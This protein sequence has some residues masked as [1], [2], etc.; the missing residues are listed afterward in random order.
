MTGPES[1]GD[2][3]AVV[4][5]VDGS[6]AALRAVRWAAGEAVRRR[7]TLLLVHATSAT[8]LHAGPASAGLVVEDVG[9][10]VEQ[11][12]RQILRVAH[13]A[14]EEVTV[15]DVGLRVD[16]ESPAIALRHA[17]RTAALLVLGATGRGVVGTAL[18]SVTLTVASHAE[19]PVVVV[20]GEDSAASDRP[21]V[22]GVD[23]GPQS[24]AALAHAFDAAAARGAPLTAVHV[25]SDNDTERFH[26]RHYLEL[27]AWERMRD[28]E[29]RALA[30]RLAGWSQRYPDVVVRRRIEHA[31]PPRVLIEQSAR[32]GLVVAATR[33][34]GGFTGLLLGSTGLALIQRAGCPVMLV[35]PRDRTRTASS[36]GRG[37]VVDR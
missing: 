8:A 16:S 33:G 14:A 25:W 17:S 2:A 31:D 5:G 15:L 7:T 24:D 29:E 19:C 35:G 21:I 18:G 12:A 22:V 3:R 13:R 11:E 30:E 4:V 9:A 23:G 32:A 36:S 37:S 28:V 6:D 34:R 26:L 27:T 10:R 20:R 1:R